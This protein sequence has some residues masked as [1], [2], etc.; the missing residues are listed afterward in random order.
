MVAKEFEIEDLSPVLCINAH[1]DDESF[2]FGGIISKLARIKRPIYIVSLTHGEAGHSSI[3]LIGDLA[4]I[5]KTELILAASKLGLTPEK[6]IVESLPDG[7][8]ADHREVV[9]SV[10]VDLVKKHQPGLIL[11]MHPN[12]TSHSDH[13]VVAEVILALKNLGQLKNTRIMLQYLPNKF[14]PSQNDVV[15]RTSIKDFLEQK[16]LAIKEHKT[17]GKDAERIIP[18]LLQEE[19]FLLIR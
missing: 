18:K 8:L 15:I 7:K 2:G 1:P 14:T 13:I 3:P 12:S 6:I 9:E 19:F 5:R 16:I 4:T 10:I 11:T 17:Q